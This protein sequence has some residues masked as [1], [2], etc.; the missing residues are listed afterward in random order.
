MGSEV[1]A[2]MSSELD[3]VV[4]PE[5]GNVSVEPLLS[6]SKGAGLDFLS[7]APPAIEGIWYRVIK[8]PS[9]HQPITK[10]ST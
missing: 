9:N 5:G 3:W 4:D 7:S 10:V 8:N 6:G 1:T 2:R